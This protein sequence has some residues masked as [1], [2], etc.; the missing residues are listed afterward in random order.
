VPT[1]G[2]IG[3]VDRDLGVLDAPGGVGVLALHS[4]RMHPLFHISG[5]I[6]DQDCAGVAEGVDDIV[7]QVFADGVDVPFRWWLN[8]T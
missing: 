5:F 3:Q 2:G 1:R 4:D 7:T 8:Q 6:E